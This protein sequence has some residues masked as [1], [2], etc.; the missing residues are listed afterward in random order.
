MVRWLL[1]ALLAVA[2]SAAA[3]ELP[4]PVPAEVLRVIDGDTLVVRAR[5]WLGQDVRTRVR[6]AGIDAPE[7]SGRCPGE[8]ALAVRARAR[9][10]DLLAAG[11]VRLFDVRHGK[12]GGRVIARVRLDDGRD[13]GVVLMAA[14]LARAYA[15]GRR[16]TWCSE[17]TSSRFPTAG[18]PRTSGR[19]S[20]TADVVV[21]E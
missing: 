10:E 7:L 5:I 1:C 3:D 14:G 21:Q 2:G 8:R 13:L 20:G 12:Y 17:A 9:V 11:E 15:G 6:I 18:R 19:D 4:G 16:T